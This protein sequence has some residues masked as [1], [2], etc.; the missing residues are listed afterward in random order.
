[1][2]MIGALVRRFTAEELKKR[3][4]RGNGRIDTYRINRAA[5]AEANYDGYIKPLETVLTI[6]AALE[7]AVS[8]RLHRAR[9]AVSAAINAPAI[10][11][12]FPREI[13]PS[14]TLALS[15]GYVSSQHL[16]SSGKWAWESIAWPPCRRAP[17]DW[18]FAIPGAG[19]LVDLSGPGGVYVTL[20]ASRTVHGTLRSEICPD[21]DGI[22]IADILKHDMLS[23]NVVDAFEGGCKKR[24]ALGAHN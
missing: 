4:K 19:L 8:P 12:G 10:V 22:G 6:M 18:T 17:S 21:H 11:G 13:G 24:P 20:N 16:D 5:A 7:A 3:K 14:V 1:M 15:Q 9:L 23:R 2:F